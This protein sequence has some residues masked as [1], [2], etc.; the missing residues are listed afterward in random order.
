V[1]WRLRHFGNEEQGRAVAALQRQVWL[2]VV[3]R[4][5]AL[6]GEAGLRQSDLAKS[7]GVSR[8]QI[9]EWLSDP[10]H[11]TLK[12]A[13]RLMLAMDAQ[14][15]CALMNQRD[16]AGPPAP[17]PARLMLLL[18]GIAA[19]F[20]LGGEPVMAAPAS[21]LRLLARPEVVA[22]M[23]GPA[24]ALFWRADCGPC[25]LELK[26]LAAL[27]AA[28]APVRVYT[29]ALDSPRVAKQRLETLGVDQGLALA[30]LDAPESVLAAYSD[31]A[32]RLPLAVAIARTGEICA[33][34][35]GL[36]GTD[37]VRAWARSC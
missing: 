27:R 24:V 34:H 37:R 35:V 11:M 8:P 21:N 33:R 13:G 4:F 25:L 29:V 17:G 36:L 14:L 7:L 31:G 16:A 3:A 5:E 19:F 28:A 10:A 20:V 18:A 1:A 12:A 6:R 15:T 26:G 9:H 2:Q 32:P 30:A 22:R 23:D